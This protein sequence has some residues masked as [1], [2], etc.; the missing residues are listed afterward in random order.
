M[1]GKEAPAWYPAGLTWCL[2]PLCPTEG[3]LPLPL[4][5]HGVLRAILELESRMMAGPGHRLRQNKAG[6]GQAWFLHR[7]HTPAPGPQGKAL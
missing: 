2:Q 3:N 1:S 5:L 4:P 7:L 6:S